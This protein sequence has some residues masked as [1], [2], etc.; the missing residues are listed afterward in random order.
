MHDALT[1]TREHWP[2]L[3]YYERFEQVVSLVLTALVSLVIVAALAHLLMRVVLLFLFGLIDPAEQSVFQAIFGM[4]MT[5]LIA[6]EFNH[7]ILGVL[8]RKQSTGGGSARP[9]RRVP[10]GARSGP[11]RHV[12][13]D[14]S[15]CH[16]VD[17][18]LASPGARHRNR[19][20]HC[21]DMFRS[22]TRFGMLTALLVVA[23]L[24][25]SQLALAS[26]VCPEA[27]DP[28]AMAEMAARGEPCSGMDSE[29]PL[30]CQ[31]HAAS[32][33]QHVDPGKLVTPS[34]PLLVQVFMLPPVGGWSLPQ[35]VPPSADKSIHPPPDPVF[36]ATGRLRV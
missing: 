8:E 27:I 3:T 36:L 15:M 33:S 7:S 30:L 9:R 21:A 17:P 29:Q 23:S 24:L 31:Q 35:P 28:D 4:I 10:A 16:V 2:T 20:V 6:L 25:F 26:Y 19:L 11:A 14:L 5:V 12:Q 34:P 32:A 18:V 13:E 22:R 1:D